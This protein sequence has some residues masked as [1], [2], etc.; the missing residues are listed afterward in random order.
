MDRGVAR[1]L[2]WWAKALRLPNDGVAF[3]PLN[4]FPPPGSVDLL[5]FAYGVSG[6]EGLGAAMLREDG[7]GQVICYFVE[8]AW[9]PHEMRYHINI[10]EGIAGNAGPATRRRRPRNRCRC[11]DSGLPIERAS[12][13]RSSLSRWSWR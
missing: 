4:H 8:H 7:D 12:S 3:F 10:K 2:R 5:E 13:R 9:N 11:R 1:D 6:V